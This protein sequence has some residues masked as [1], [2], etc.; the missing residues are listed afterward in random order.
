MNLQIY[1]VAQQKAKWFGKLDRFHITGVYGECSCG[2]VQN[3]SIFDK[4]YF[5]PH[6]SIDQEIIDHI[7]HQIS[8]LNIKKSFY[9]RPFLQVGD[10]RENRLRA[11][12]YVVAICHQTYQLKSEKKNLWGW[13]Y[14]EDGFV[15]LMQENPK[16]MWPEVAMNMPLEELS[17]HLAE[18]FSDSGGVQDTTLDRLPER[19]SLFQDVASFVVEEFHGSFEELLYQTEN[20]LNNQGKGYLEILSKME[21]FKDPLQKKSLFLLKLLADAGLYE[22]KNAREIEPIM[23]YHMMRVLLRTGAVRIHDVQLQQQLIDRVPMEDE[24]DIRAM[25]VKAMKQIGLKSGHGVLK[26]NDFFWPLGRSCCNEVK[27]CVDLH[28]EKDPCSFEQVVALKSHDRCVFA[29]FCK[30]ASDETYREIWQP[31]VKTHYY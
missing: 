22:I 2:M 17:H 28:C 23:D 11:F 20:K 27:L 15:R 24:S 12:F 10:S 30:G 25:C 21:A 4:K 3:I 14:L 7:S 6:L 5:M 9:N 19:V 16:W 13:D 29:D 18:V 1:C 26:M 8:N 31:V